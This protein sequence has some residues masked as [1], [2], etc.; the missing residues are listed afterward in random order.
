MFPFYGGKC[1]SRKVVHNCAEIFS[2]GRSKEADDAQKGRL[3]ET[4]TE[5]TVQR[6]EE[7]I[8]A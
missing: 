7:F 1:L 3:V 4:A 2:Q 6:V 5:V 8:R